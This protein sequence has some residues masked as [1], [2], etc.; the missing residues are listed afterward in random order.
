MIRLGNYFYQHSRKRRWDEAVTEFRVALSHEPGA[1]D[2]LFSI[3]EA[4][5]Q[6]AAQTRRRADWESAEAAALEYIRAHPGNPQIPLRLAL[7]RRSLND[8]PGAW[9]ALQTAFQF[10][11]SGA[12]LS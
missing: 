12:E 3:A 10:D 1:E 6:R 8:A 9:N 2:S 11:L 5:Y 7:A 4:L